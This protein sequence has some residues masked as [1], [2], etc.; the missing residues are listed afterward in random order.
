MEQSALDNKVIIPLKDG[1]N[2][3]HHGQ[4]LGVVLGLLPFLWIN[5]NVTRTLVKLE[6]IGIQGERNTSEAVSDRGDK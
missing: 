4:E 3:F 1:V 5:S 2:I 6:T